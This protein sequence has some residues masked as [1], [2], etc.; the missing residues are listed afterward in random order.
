MQFFL[1]RSF[2]IWL[3]F[4]LDTNSSTKTLLWRTNEGNSTWVRV[5]KCFETWSITSLRVRSLFIL[6]FF[7]FFFLDGPGVE[8]DR[9]GGDGDVPVTGVDEVLA[10]VDACFPLIWLVKT[11]WIQSGACFLV[12]VCSFDFFSLQVVRGHFWFLMWMK[13]KGLSWVGGANEGTTKIFSG[14]TKTSILPLTLLDSNIWKSSS[15]M[16]FLSLRSFTVF[17]TA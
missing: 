15:F 7:D 8:K 4:L 14:R 2:I 5:G 1:E 3:I 12:K 9:V 10:G 6:G 11:V 16:R 13:R 17:F